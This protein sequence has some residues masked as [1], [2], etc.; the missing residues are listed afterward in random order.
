MAM[1]ILSRLSRLILFSK[2]QSLKARQSA[3]A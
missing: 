3:A 2:V 1:A